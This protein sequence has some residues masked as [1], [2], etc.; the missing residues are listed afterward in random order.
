MRRHERERGRKGRGGESK[1]GEGRGLDGRK[2]EGKRMLH[3]M[4]GQRRYLAVAKS[5]LSASNPPGPSH[6]PL[7]DPE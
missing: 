5:M 2:E 1:V 4:P 3:Q 7:P 6:L